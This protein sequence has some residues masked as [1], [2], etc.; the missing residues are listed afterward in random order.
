LR[1]AIE[2]TK[3]LPGSHGIFNMSAN[4]HSGLDQRARVMVEIVGGQ[5]TLAKD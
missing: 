3:D 2:D 5:W 4:D 1:A